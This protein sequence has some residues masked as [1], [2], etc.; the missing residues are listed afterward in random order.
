MARRSA[1]HA[2]ERRHRRDVGDVVPARSPGQRLVT[3][4]S[5]TEMVGG[6]AKLS[7]QR[8]GVLPNRLTVRTCRRWSKC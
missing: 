6:P 2:G 4:G 8:N 1:L 7:V 5:A 3:I